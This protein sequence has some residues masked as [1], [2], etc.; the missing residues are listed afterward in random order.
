MVTFPVSCY[1]Q[2]KSTTE[3]QFLYRKVCYC[4]VGYRLAFP[5]LFLEAEVTEN[6]Q[7]RR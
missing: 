4:T 3:V 6:R 5:G 1:K 7:C 2:E